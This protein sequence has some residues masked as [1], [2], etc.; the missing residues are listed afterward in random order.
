MAWFGGFIVIAFFTGQL[1]NMLK[2]AMSSAF[3]SAPVFAWLNYS[4]VRSEQKLSSGIQ[5]LSIIGFMF[6]LGFA[7]L[8]VANTMGI[9][10]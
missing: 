7:L 4:L 10:G 9:F 6:L 3:V 5:A 1:G 2:F 8:Y